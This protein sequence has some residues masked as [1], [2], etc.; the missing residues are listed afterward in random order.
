MVCTTPI[1]CAQDPQNILEIRKQYDRWQNFLKNEKY[2]TKKYFEI[3][4]GEEYQEHEWVDNFKKY[5]DKYEGI[6]YFITTELTLINDKK[7]G[8]MFSTYE[9]SPSGDWHVY[10]EH[11]YWPSGELFFTL[12][13]MVTSSSIHYTDTGEPLTI[14]R[15]LYFNKKGEIIRKLESTY[16]SQSKKE[17]KNQQYLDREIKHWLTTKDFPFCNLNEKGIKP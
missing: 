11:Y 10:S 2:D 14:E 8:V 17:L 6:D 4:S 5:Q 12:W 16:G 3:Y 15:R 7:I 9:T 1:F 13:R